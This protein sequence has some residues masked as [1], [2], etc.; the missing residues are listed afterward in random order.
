[1]SGPARP[2]RGAAPAAGMASRPTTTAEPWA[3]QTGSQPAAS[4][5][6]RGSPIMRASAAQAGQDQQGPAIRR[7][8]GGEAVGGGHA[9]RPAEHGA[10]ER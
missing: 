7:A 2:K 5:R 6:A 10:A 4:N 9:V 3:A 1:M 8:F